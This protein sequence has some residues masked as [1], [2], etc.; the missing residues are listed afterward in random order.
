[1]KIAIEIV[2]LPINSM[3][4]FQFADCKRFPEAIYPQHPSGVLNK[5]ERRT[6]FLLSL[7]EPLDLVDQNVVE[8]IGIEFLGMDFFREIQWVL[9]EDM[10][11]STKIEMVQM[12]EK[13][14]LFKVGFVQKNHGTTWDIMGHMLN[15]RTSFIAVTVEDEESHV[16]GF[17]VLDAWDPM[18]T[19]DRGM[20]QPRSM[21]LL[22]DAYRCI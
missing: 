13:W 12:V 10:G 22:M 3:V 15:A 7:I 6:K 14:D 21:A 5:A 11:I 20:I 2:D 19:G 4:I 16:V 17:A 8:K 9:F 18:G 1:L